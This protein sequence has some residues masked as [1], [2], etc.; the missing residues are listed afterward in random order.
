[1]NLQVL[2]V[3]KVNVTRFCQSKYDSSPV[4][5]S[6][7]GLQC[8]NNQVHSHFFSFIYKVQNVPNWRDSDV[9]V[10]VQTLGRQ[11]WA[12]TVAPQRVCAYLQCWLD[13]LFTLPPLPSLIKT[14]KAQLWNSFVEE[15]Q[16]VC[17]IWICT[18]WWTSSYL[19][20]N[21]IWIYYRC[22]DGKRMDFLCIFKCMH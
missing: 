21:I 7:H 10:F 16:H 11:F 15:K 22:C 20:T 12:W 6:Q 1:M 19:N 13:G 3:G 17:H 14:A 2:I 18:N 5:R 8:T 4:L 9:V